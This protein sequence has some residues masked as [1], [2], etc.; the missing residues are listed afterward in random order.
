MLRRHDELQ[1]VDS[2]STAS[3]P[4]YPLLTPDTV[5]GKRQ[6][7]KLFRTQH[8]MPIGS[9][10]RRAVI[11]TLGES[12]PFEQLPY[13]CFQEARKVLAEDR[14]EKVKTIELFRARIAQLM[15]VDPAACG[16]E[17]KKQRR[18]DSMRKKLEKYK[19][20]ADINDPLVKK[21]FE[22]GHGMDFTIVCRGQGL[23][24]SIGDMNK[25]I[26]RYLADRK[27]REMRRKIVMQ[28]ITQMS[29]IP[30]V[31]PHIDPVAS[32]ELTFG[33]R[34]VQPGEFIPSARTETPPTVD[35]QVFDK[36]ERMVTIVAIDSDVPNVQKNGFDYRCHGIWINVPIHPTRPIV[37]LEKLSKE[38]TIM[39]W[40]PPFAQ[41][42]SSYHRLSFFVFQ[43]AE[44]RP[45]L[46]IAPLA[47]RFKRD[48]FILRSFIARCGIDQSNQLKL[49]GITMFRT[50]WDEGTEDVMKRH[51]ILGWDIE[52]KREKIQKLPHI[53]TK[54]DGS[55]YR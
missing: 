23:T 15:E 44:N 7:K 18:L 42:G 25:P 20:L 11:K 55:R 41:K 32:V 13:Q 31:L 30:D 2:S 50:Q 10:R 26:Y 4:P 24:R 29:V 9:R 40:L 45:L 52:F 53:I 27:W 34:K 1:T 33:R 47:E 3:A 6:E 54:K 46:E 16:G 19:I 43:Q 8:K 12:I 38:Q 48:G 49:V 28:R 39:P 17:E 51:G 5:V 37:S 21:K 35:I 22:D 14:E 36:G